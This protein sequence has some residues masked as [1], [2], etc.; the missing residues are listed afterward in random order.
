MPDADGK[1]RVPPS[2]VGAHIRGTT[3]IAVHAGGGGGMLSAGG[4]DAAAQALHEGGSIPAGFSRNPQVVARIV[5]RYAELFPGESMVGN[6][7]LFDA[8]KGSMVAM[9]KQRDAVVAFERTA[10]K[11]LDLFLTQAKKVIDSGSPLINQPL[12]AVN[13]KL[14]GDQDLAA[15]NT[16]RQVALTE[17]AK[18]TNNPS[19]AGQLSD[20]ARH[21][22]TSLIPAEATLGQIYSVANILKQDM[23][24]RRESYDQSLGEMKSHF[25]GSAKTNPAQQPTQ[26]GASPSSQQANP[27]PTGYIKNHVYG[28][29]T[30]L[31]GDPNNPASWKK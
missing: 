14:L 25:G 5:N 10:G 24:N 27:N 21:E 17:I 30:Y 28:G 23:A 12:R 20:S 7:A 16:A 29:L 11:N 31:G 8:A 6:K 3:S 19:L 22:V 15:Y 4:L 18:V 26:Q 2:A 1:Y 13:S 9:Q